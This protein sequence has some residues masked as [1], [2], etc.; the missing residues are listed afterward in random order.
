M[1]HQLGITPLPSDLEKFLIAVKET[2]DIRLKFVET[3]ATLES[4]TLWLLKKGPI[5]VGPM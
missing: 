3:C 2:I 1:L 4:A 5:R